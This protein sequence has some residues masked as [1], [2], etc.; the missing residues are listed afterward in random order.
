MLHL[1][2]LSQGAPRS[3][4][5]IGVDFGGTKIDVA[6][7]SATG[8]ILER[9]RLPTL[10][11][12]GPDQ[13]LQRVAEVVRKLT[14]GAE[15]H[16]IAVVGHAA[17]CPGVVQDDRIQLA[18][19][20]PGWEDLAISRRLAQAFEVDSVPVW[21][22]VRAGALAEA[23]RGNLRG[24][25][26][27]LYLSLGTGIAAAITINGSVLAGAHHAAGEI[28]YVGIEMA[29]SSS[30]DRAPLEEVIGG[31]ALG[32]RASRLLGEDVDAEA[33]FNRTDPEAQQ[34]LHHALGVLAAAVANF[35]VLI[36][37]ARV[38]VGG[39]MMASAAPL[40]A[41][42]RAQLNRTV[43]FPP[44]VLAARFTEDAS[45]H[46]AVTLALNAAERRPGP[47]RAALTH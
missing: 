29:P 46:G 47:L 3:T 11:R 4:A 16:G 42:L 6:L 33:L 24:A 21:N 28:G 45:L 20:L 32:E 34:I 40:L 43:P 9:L 26:P 25:D 13:A 31:K 10:A 23:L 17:V 14:A 2:Q 8:S 1:D 37:P 5:V 41:V 22:D 36:D 38:V 19:N 7:A 39:G 18:P 27:G 30:T 44:E 15:E 12:E 35:A